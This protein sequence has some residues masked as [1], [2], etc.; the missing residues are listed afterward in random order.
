[1]THWLLRKTAC[2]KNKTSPGERPAEC[3]ITSEKAKNGVICTQLNV[4][5]A[6]LKGLGSTERNVPILNQALVEIQSFKLSSD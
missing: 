6:H 3:L 4:F 1:M 2:D 5:K